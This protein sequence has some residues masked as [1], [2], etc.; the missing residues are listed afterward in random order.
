MTLTGPGGVGKTR[1]ALRAAEEVAADFIDGA[2]FVDLAPLA[3]PALVPAGNRP[4]PRRARGGRPAARRAARGRSARAASGCWCWTTWSTC[5]GRCRTS[6]PSSRPARTWWCWPPAGRCWRHPGSTSSPCRRWPCPRPGRRRPR[7]SA[8]RRPWRSSRRGPTAADPGFALTDAN[9]AAVAEICRRLDGL[10]LALELAAARVRHLPPA[11]LLAR[12]D[13]RLPLLTGGPRDQP[14]RQRTLREAIAWSHD[15]LAPDEQALFRRLAVFAG[16]FGLEAA[17]AVA[18]APGSPGIE[19]VDG[20]ATLADQSLLHRVE[21]NDGAARFAMLE[22]V[23]EFALERLAESGEAEAVRRA[24]AALLPGPRRGG[25]AAPDGRGAGGVVRPAGGRARQPARRPGLVRRHAATP[26]RSCAWRRRCGASGTTRGH[27]QRGPRV[28]GAGPRPARD[29]HRRRGPRQGAERPGVLADSQ[30]D[31]DRA[32]VAARGG[33]GALARGRR[34]GGHRPRARQPRHLAPRCGESWIGRPTPSSRRPSPSSAR[35]ATSDSLAV[36]LDG[37]GAASRPAGRPRPGGIAL[38]TECLA[39]LRAGSATR[40]AVASGLRTPGQ[41]GVPD[42]RIPRSR[43]G[44]PEEGLELLRTLGHRQEHRLHP[45]QPRA[46]AATSWATSRRGAGAGRG[47][48]RALRTRRSRRRGLVALGLGYVAQAQG[49]LPSAA[50]VLRGGPERLPRRRRHRRD[51]RMPGGA[52]RRRGP[53]GRRGRRPRLLRRGGGAAGGD[54]A[55]AARTVDRRARADVAAAT[56]GRPRPGGVPP[57]VGEGAGAAG[58]AGRRGGAGLRRG[59]RRR[60]GRTGHRRTRRRPRP[61]P[62][63]D[64]RARGAWRWWP[65]A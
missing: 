16:G 46:G 57:G 18:G 42:G 29:G 37:P 1:L 9:A 13:R 28:A 59:H 22:T 6:S 51:R 62:P 34:P 53:P 5:W 14:A 64:A 26:R 41:R 12:L 15:L 49:E 8:G 23:R 7:R 31:L 4:G 38:A 33:A 25:R 47:R 30:G 65:R 48:P 40:E 32:E 55:P 56:R 20:L 63:H 27:L 39:T 45:R 44:S 11:E 24:H 43:C 54:R 10:P 19:T 3:D 60:P 2:A 50:R 36:A 52:G 61:G 58:G 21:A 35:R 17:E